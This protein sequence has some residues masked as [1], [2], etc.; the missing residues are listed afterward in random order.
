MHNRAPS[1]RVSTCVTLKATQPS[2]RFKSFNEGLFNTIN[3]L[4]ET[5][6]NNQGRWP[7]KQHQAM[8]SVIHQLSA[9]LSYRCHLFSVL[10]TNFT[11][12]MLRLL[13]SLQQRQAS[14]LSQA[15]SLQSLIDLVSITAAM[16]SVTSTA[17]SFANV[18]RID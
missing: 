2:T 16:C 17:R 8:L 9:H 14:S 13:S 10:S 4:I 1:L 6:L 5:C 11:Q 12:R 18:F 3:T 7:N 15:R